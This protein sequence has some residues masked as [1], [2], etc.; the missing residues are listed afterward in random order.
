M[1]LHEST[2]VMILY[3]NITDNIRNLSFL[4]VLAKLPHK[5]DIR[6]STAPLNAM[7]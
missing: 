1:R 4:R 3:R 2:I 6:P 5:K 7:N